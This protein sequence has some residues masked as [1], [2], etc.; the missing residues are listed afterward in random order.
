[1]KGRACLARLVN[2]THITSHRSSG[3]G[4]FYSP[5][6][7]QCASLW[8]TKAT[9]RNV[10]GEPAGVDHEVIVAQDPD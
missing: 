10:Y 5:V 3:K 8:I 1:M 7:M 9:F 2:V 6:D 4:D